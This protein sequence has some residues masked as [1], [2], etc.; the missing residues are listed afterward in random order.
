MIKLEIRNGKMGGG[1]G[2]TEILILILCT[3][4]L[5]A[6]Y[7]SHKWMGLMCPFTLSVASPDSIKPH[8]PHVSDILTWFFTAPTLICRPRMSLPHAL[9]LTVQPNTTCTLPPSTTQH[10]NIKH[11]FNRSQSQPTP[12]ILDRFCLL[13]FFHYHSSYHSNIISIIVT[14]II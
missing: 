2:H 5:K 14:Y 12:L 8:D 11:L 9:P 6:M 10:T 13:F 4:C 1:R 3:H 7:E